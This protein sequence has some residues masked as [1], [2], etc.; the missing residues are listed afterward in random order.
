MELSLQACGLCGVLST[1]HWAEMAACDL[2]PPPCLLAAGCTA[3]AR[4]RSRLP[5]VIVSVIPCRR[6][7]PER[8]GLIGPAR[9]RHAAAPAARTWHRSMRGQRCLHLLGNH[10]GSHALAVG[11]GRRMADC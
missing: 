11:V 8:G 9:P 5:V 1:Q 6:T 10:P 7:P 3:G 4:A 2:L